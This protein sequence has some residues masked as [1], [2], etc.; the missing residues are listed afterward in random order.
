MIKVVFNYINRRVSK[1]PFRMEFKISQIKPLTFSNEYKPKPHPLLKCIIFVLFEVKDVDV[2][3]LW[4]GNC[5]MT[6]NC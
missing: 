4:H 2:D 5:L 1:S 3:A 6:D